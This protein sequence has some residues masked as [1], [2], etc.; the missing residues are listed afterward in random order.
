MKN[1]PSEVP[2]IIKNITP[3]TEQSGPVSHDA[4]L[5]QIPDTV[6]KVPEFVYELLT[7][8]EQTI[9]DKSKD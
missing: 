6:K 3:V 1:K 8:A 2:D 7:E 9:C 5:M 4:D